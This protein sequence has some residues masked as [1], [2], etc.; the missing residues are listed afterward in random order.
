MLYLTSEDIKKEI[1]HVAVDNG[2]R[3][4]VAVNCAHN[5]L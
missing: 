4:V 5:R 2:V 3:I 1:I